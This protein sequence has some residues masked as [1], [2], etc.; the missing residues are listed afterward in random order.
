MAAIGI[1][2]LRERLLRAAAGEPAAVLANVSALAKAPSALLRAV[3]TELAHWPGVPLLTVDSLGRLPGAH[4]TIAAAAAAVGAPQPRR[5]ARRQ[6]PNTRKCE[7]AGRTFVRECCRDWEIDE[8]R[9]ADAVLVANELI[10]N[11]IRHTY[12]PPDVR[13]GLRRDELTVAVGDGDPTTPHTTGSTAVHGLT[14]VR[15]LCRAWGTAP[16]LDG[17]KVVWAAL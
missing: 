5:S 3:T 13:M 14:I 15:R 2:D 1:R 10:E 4:T 11:T 16:T 12:Y 8:D 9:V 17:G 7:Q 6:L